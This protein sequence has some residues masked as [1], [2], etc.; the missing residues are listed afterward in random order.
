[1]GARQ[2]DHILGR[3]LETDPIES[4]GANDYA[5]PAD[6][7]NMRDLD[8]RLWEGMGS[9][10]GPADRRKMVAK[11]VAQ[12]DRPSRGVL[13]TWANGIRKVSRSIGE[14]ISRNRRGIVVGAAGLAG[15]MCVAVSMGI[16]A[17][18]CITATSVAVTAQ[19][20]TSASCRGVMPGG[21]RPNWGGFAADSAID[22]LSTY[23]GG[24]P[25]L[26]IPAQ[27]LSAE[28]G[29][30][31]AAVIT[32]HSAAIGTASAATAGC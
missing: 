30:A 1:M 8:G 21:S 16:A 28:F 25:S 2:Y 27:R 3:F 20:A 9:G 15:A 23:A 29:A 13:R 18:G 32:G 7:V 31:G 6:P 22:A 5:Y 24:L 12:A 14:V 19:L 11:M 4:G 10:F 26:G 17:G